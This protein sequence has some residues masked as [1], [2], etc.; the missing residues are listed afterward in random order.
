MLVI[1]NPGLDCLSIAPLQVPDYLDHIKNPMDFSTMR[2]RIDGHV[3]RSLDDLEADFDLVISNCMH[4]NAKDTFFYKAAQRMQDHGGTVLRRARR[5]AAR[6]GF[7]LPG[8][9]H[10]PE[11]PQAEAASFCWEDGEFVLSGHCSVSSF[12]PKVFNCSH[13]Q[14]SVTV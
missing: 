10:L 13:E 6:I 12:T 9:L 3:Y 5:E 8:G 4:Y 7:D 1:P 11:A 2:K 14:A